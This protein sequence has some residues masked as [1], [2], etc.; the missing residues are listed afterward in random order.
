[1]IFG[2]SFMKRLLSA[3]LI[4]YSLIISNA[5]FIQGLIAF[6]LRPTFSQFTLFVISVFWIVFSYL[7]T[8][9]FF[10]PVVIKRSLLLQ[11]I[12]DVITPLSFAGLGL[13]T[14]ALLVTSGGSVQILI[15]FLFL[16]ALSLHI[17]AVK[18]LLAWRPSKLKRYSR[19]NVAKQVVQSSAHQQSSEQQ[20]SEQQSNEQ[21]KGSRLDNN[22]QNFR[23]AT[24]NG[25]NS[26]Q[27][28]QFTISSTATLTSTA[29]VNG[30][31]RSEASQKLTNNPQK[32]TDYEEAQLSD[33][34]GQFLKGLSNIFSD[35]PDES[36]T[37]ID[38]ESNSLTPTG[39]TRSAN[40]V[41]E[42]RRN[43]LK[44]IGGA[45]LGLV[46]GSMFNPRQAGAAFFG[47]VPGPGT[48]A[49]KDST[50]AQIDPAIKKPTDGYGICEI[51]D[52]S[53]AY[54]GYVNKE[55][56]W[57][58]AREDSTGSYR[59]AKGNDNFSSNWSNRTS[60]TY[61]YYDLIF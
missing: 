57:Y 5:L 29:T 3:I 50:G 43:F 60:L 39:L 15:L 20:S 40:S 59:Y 12:F 58:I 41:D 4:I 18:N 46:M 30:L 31:V 28:A 38:G 19:K 35:S 25:Q 17:M 47:S 8:F 16:P 7:K 26:E 34:P 22:Q 52:N 21:Q 13:L 14:I 56:A 45:G 23:P 11:A 36:G 53:P 2:M 48:V 9:S 32:P 44:L 33:L 37:I 1:V 51:D 10:I 55:G 61:N 49:V 24:T 54:Y 6:F 42:Q 27:S